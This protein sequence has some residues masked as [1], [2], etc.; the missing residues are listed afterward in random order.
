MAHFH[1]FIPGI[2]S[3]MRG[4]QHFSL[5]HFLPWWCDTWFISSTTVCTEYQSEV[6]SS[7]RNKWQFL[8]ND[9]RSIMLIYA[10]LLALYE[11]IAL[12]L[13]QR[14][15]WGWG[16]KRDGL[17]CWRRCLLQNLLFHT[18]S[19]TCTDRKCFI[20]DSISWKNI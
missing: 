5:T 1:D 15:G 2:S 16:R 13:R 8:R 9:S 10:M 4:I 7:R 3:T 14:W 20:K 18:G 17:N 11:D 6:K 19:M 12:L